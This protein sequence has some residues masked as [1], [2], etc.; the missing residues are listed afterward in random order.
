MRQWLT[1]IVAAS[2]E[3]AATTG[4]AQDLNCRGVAFSPTPWTMVTVEIWR[5][6]TEV[7]LHHAR[8]QDTVADIPI[9]TA[10]RSMEN[11]TTTFAFEHPRASVAIPALGGPGAVRGAVIMNSERLPISLGCRTLEPPGD[12][13]QHTVRFIRVQPDVQLEVLDWGG[14]GRPLIL[15]HGLGTTAHDF[16]RFAPQLTAEYRVI[17]ITRRGSGRSSEPDS[18]Y[19]PTRLAEDVLAVADSLGM[20]KPIVVGHSLAGATLSAIASRAPARVAGLVYLDAAY[21]Y[22]YIDSTHVGV[23]EPKPEDLHKCP[24]SATEQIENGT[25]VY[26]RIPVPVLAIYAMDPD[27]NT[28]TYVSSAPWS[29]A[30]QSREFEKGVPSAHVVRIPNASHN[31]FDSNPAQVLSEIRAFVATL[32]PDTTSRSRSQRPR[33]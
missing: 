6:G 5:R 3:T 30:Q 2:I 1:L 9:T 12:N 11:G 16:D 26:R 29:K 18:G 17:A 15:L 27:W 7:T 33:E 24:C 32:P 13:S 31:V 10:S 22:A 23:F 19:S 25:Q 21:P 14:S 20:G 8:V 4:D 28:A